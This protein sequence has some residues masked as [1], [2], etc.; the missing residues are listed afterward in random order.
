MATTAIRTID[1]V[2]DC[3]MNSLLFSTAHHTSCSAAADVALAQPRAARWR[4]SIS[5]LGRLAGQ[6]GHDTGSRSWRRC[7]SLPSVAT[8]AR[9]LPLLD[10]D[11]LLDQ[12]AVHHH[13]R[14]RDRA[15]ERG[16]FVV[17][18]GAEGDRRTAA[19]NRASASP[20]LRSCRAVLCGLGG[21]EQRFVQ[22]F[23]PHLPQVEV[24]EHRLLAERR[25]VLLVPGVNLLDRR[26]RLAE[27]DPA[28][29]L[30][31]VV[32]VLAELLGQAD[33]AVP[34]AS[35]GCAGPCRRSAW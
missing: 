4:L 31:Q 27:H 8:V 34:D 9:K 3:K 7:F 28:D 14:L 2:S 10:A 33:R 1:S 25:I 30:L 23:G 32:A 35:A 11:G 15:V 26:V 29:Q 18:V 19:A 22:L 13:Q 16:G 6:G 5:L 12:V 20:A 24:A 21:D 17:F